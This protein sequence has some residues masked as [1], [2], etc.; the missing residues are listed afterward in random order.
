MSIQS[1]IERIVSAKS[2]IADAIEIKGV[3]VPTGSSIDDL[4]ALILQITSGGGSGIT[5]TETADS[6]G[7]T[8][9]EV[10]AVDL[11]NDT[12]RAD[13]LLSGYTAHDSS[14]NAIVGTASSGGVTPTGTISITQNGTGIDVT[15]YAAADVAVPQTLK[16]G[17]LRSDA[18]LVKTYTLDQMVNADMEITIPAYTTTATTLKASSELSETYT[19]DLD[20]YNYFILERML[21]IPIY[22]ITSKSK[23]R[24]EYHIN[25][26]MYEVTE[27]P[28][29]SFE[30]ILDGTKLASRTTSM[31]AAGNFFRLFYWSSGTALA[32]QSTASYGTYQAVT[33]PTISSGVITMKTPVIGIRGHTTYFTSTYFNKVTDI[34]VQY[35][36]EIWRAA[37]NN[38]N[39]NGWGGFQNS[40]H[41]I[42]CANSSTHKLT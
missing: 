29:N 15:N 12:V 10:T 13:K 26:A 33:A 37:K 24:V 19:C 9:L 31:I 35:V 32:A 18:T 2:D 28:A 40:M 27:I 42:G 39:L 20:N 5:I 36:F 38:L 21:T 41:I 6:H 23:G 30:T 1:E 11:S 22:S 7:G 34:R 14:G 4:A 25:S 8:I 17:L 16:E 3:T